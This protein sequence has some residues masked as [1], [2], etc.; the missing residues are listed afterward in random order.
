MADLF[1]K[2]TVTVWN[3]QGDTGNL[4]AE[5]SWVP[6]VIQ[7]T[8]LLVSR[9]NNIQTSG[10]SEA[11]TARLHIHDEWSEWAGELVLRADGKAFFTAGDTSESSTDGNFFENMKKAVRDC[12]LITSVDRFDII[13]HWEVW[14]K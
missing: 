3:W 12:Y 5:G 2:D 4:W 8:R 7:N 10:N 1:Y 14:G 13:P 6:T 11:D 9:G